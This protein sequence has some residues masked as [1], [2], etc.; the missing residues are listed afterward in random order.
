MKERDELSPSLS[1]SSHTLNAEDGPSEALAAEM[2][3]SWA[4]GECLPA[5]HY[6]A[7]LMEMSDLPE[8]AEARP[9]CADRS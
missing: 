9:S 4:R 5:E 7:I 3:A 6:L 8:N 1:A 2:A